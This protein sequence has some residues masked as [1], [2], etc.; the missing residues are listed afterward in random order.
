MLRLFFHN[1]LKA[2]GKRKGISASMALDGIEC[3]A[4]LERPEEHHACALD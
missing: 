3:G 4:R 1:E 2:C